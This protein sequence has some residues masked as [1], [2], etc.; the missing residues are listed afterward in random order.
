MFVQGNSEG[1]KL[2]ELIFLI[3]MK[4]QNESSMIGNA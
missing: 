4:S 3:V 2:F 1:A